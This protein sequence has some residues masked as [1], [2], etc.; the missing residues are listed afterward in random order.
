MTGRGVTMRAMK[1]ARCGRG[2]QRK[3]QEPDTPDI[4][5]KDAHREALERQEPW[6]KEVNLPGDFARAAGGEDGGGDG[7]DDGTE[8]PV[9]ISRAERKGERQR[10]RRRGRDDF[11]RE[12]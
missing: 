3:R 5:L 9:P 10:S 8:E 1:S 4:D 2:W 6:S 11:E 7:G 12:R